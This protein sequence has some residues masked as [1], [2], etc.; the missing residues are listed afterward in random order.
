MSYEFQSIE[1][2]IDELKGMTGFLSSLISR[3]SGVVFM[4]IVLGVIISKLLI[5]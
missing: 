4:F 2:L 1:A 5:G 3:K